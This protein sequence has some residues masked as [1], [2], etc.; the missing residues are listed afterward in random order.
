M[1]CYFSNMPLRCVNDRWTA[2]IF[3][4]SDGHVSAK[5]RLESLAPT[6][7]STQDITNINERNAAFLLHVYNQLEAAIINLTVGQLLSILKISPPR[8]R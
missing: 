6:D 7:P 8:S 2:G 3:Q 5:S 4:Q 1:I